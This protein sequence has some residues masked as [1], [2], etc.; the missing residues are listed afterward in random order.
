[1]DH[2]RHKVKRQRS[3]KRLESSPKMN[4]QNLHHQHCHMDGRALFPLSISTLVLDMT[5]K[6]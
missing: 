2:N 6:G 4:E 3:N 5:A 1:M